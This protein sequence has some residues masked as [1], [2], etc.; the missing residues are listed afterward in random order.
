MKS[1]RDIL[2]PLPYDFIII[3]TPPS[4]CWLTESALIAA[5]HTLSAPPPNFIASKG[6]ER[7]SQFMESIGQRHPLNVL[8]VV[9]SF[10][11]P[12]GKAIK[13]FWM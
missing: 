1:L 7:L 6:L 9:L 5:Q 2:Q 12:A 4:L 8:G 3:D 13:H 10:W 11:N